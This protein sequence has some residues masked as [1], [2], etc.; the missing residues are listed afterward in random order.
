MKGDQIMQTRHNTLIP[1][2]ALA[3]MLTLL[4]GQ[5]FGQDASDRAAPRKFEG[6]WDVILKFPKKTCDRT[7]CSCPGG[8]PNIPIV[9]L[10]T[11]LKGD[12]LHRTPW[13]EPIPN[14]HRVPW[15]VN[16]PHRDGATGQLRVEH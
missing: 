9:T 16:R 7:E 1:S 12:G 6:T 5:G 15:R 3:G 10:N 8:V 14:R 13:V 11:F 4:V 2:L